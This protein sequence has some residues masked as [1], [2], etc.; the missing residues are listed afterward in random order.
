MEEVARESGGP[1]GHCSTLEAGRCLHEIS[2]SLAK[3]KLWDEASRFCGSCVELVES[4]LGPSE[5]VASL[6]YNSSVMHTEANE[7]DQAEKI[8]GDCLDMRVK[9]CGTESILYVRALCQ[10]GDILSVSSDYSAAESCFNK[11]IGILKVMPAHYHLDFGI[12]LYKLGRNQHRR[13]GY[14]DEALHCYEEALEFEKEELGPQHIFMSSIHMHMGDILLDKEDTQQ[15]KHTFKEALDVLSKADSQ[16][17][18]SS[19]SKVK[20]M[21]AVVEGKLLSI[22]AHTD[23]CIEKYQHALTLL[24]KYTPTKKRK[25]AQVCSMIG[26]EHEKKGNCHAAEKFYEESVSTMKSVFGP[27]HLDIAETLVNLSGVKS[28]LGGEHHAQATDCLEESIDIQKTRLGDCEECVSQYV[29][30][31]YSANCDKVLQFLLHEQNNVQA[32]TLTMFGAHLKTIGEYKKAELAYDDAVQ[33]LQALEGDQDLSLVDVYLGIAE[34]MAA[35]SKYDDAMEYYF[36]C[37]EI[38]DSVF[39][40]KHDDIASTLYAMGLVKHDAGLYSQALVLFA[41]S[42]VVRVELHGE[43][44]P[45]VGDAY[46]MMGF[47]EAKNGDLDTALRRLNDGLKVRK[48]LGDQL[49]EADTLINIGNLHRERNEFELALQRYDDCLNI[50]ISEMGRNN[51]SVADVL[52]ALGNVQSDMDNPQ[53]ALSHYREGE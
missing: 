35:M 17:D 31:S 52:M 18:T 22:V 23:K 10:L 38:Q 2:V 12:T 28:A 8:I 1:N 21:S 53:D 29:P 16:Y 9:T 27:Y 37:L 43:A 32:I 45:A 3:F 11:S 25:I 49:K 13:G 36:Q 51:Q 7:F 41:K 24:Q 47:V 34:L 26:A 30:S 46:D 5:L 6:L 40:E 19:S 44:H 15:A 50:R 42:L 20:I 33:I 4:N 14:L 39:G 48:S